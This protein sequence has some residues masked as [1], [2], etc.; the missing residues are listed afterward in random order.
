MCNLDVIIRSG[1]GIFVF[2][3]NSECCL[4]DCSCHLF[5]YLLIVL[6]YVILQTGVVEEECKLSGAL[7]GPAELENTQ[8]DAIKTFR[9]RLECHASAADDDDNWDNYANDERQ[10]AAE[11]AV[12][13]SCIQDSSEKQSQD[14]DANVDEVGL[15]RPSTTLE[16]EITTVPCT[17]TQ[18]PNSLSQC[19]TSDD[20]RRQHNALDQRSQTVNAD[21]KEAEH[22]CNSPTDRHD[23]QPDDTN[24]ENFDQKPQTPPA[25]REEYQNIDKE[26][27]TTVQDQECQHN[28]NDG[29]IDLETRQD[30]ECQ[31]TQEA[32]QLS[33]REIQT[34]EI[35]M[36]VAATE[37]DADGM[38]DAATT[39][40]TSLV[41]VWFLTVD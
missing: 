30:V 16:S 34:D 12:K 33:S 31:T 13:V 36:T 3:P 2:S 20:R 41:K 15:S 23:H 39:T 25:Q 18:I 17:E 35:R 29:Q 32:C 40:D 5:D 6:L 24:S 19:L 38:T 8:Q 7:L 9:D 37:T 27:Q 14:D 21:A 28:S 10:L 11:S 4:H 22:Q 1:V 26:C